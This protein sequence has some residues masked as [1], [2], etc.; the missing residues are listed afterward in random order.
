[1]VFVGTHITLLD[2][3]RQPALQQQQK[4]EMPSNKHHENIRDPLR[5]SLKPL[6]TRTERH[7]WLGK[8]NVMLY[9]EVVIML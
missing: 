7:T 5:K 1:M 3:Y 8:E 9:Y 6:N 4:D 2:A